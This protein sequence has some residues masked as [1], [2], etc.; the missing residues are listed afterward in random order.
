MWLRHRNQA[1]KRGSFVCLG[2]K[3]KEATLKAGYWCILTR[4]KRGSWCLNSSK[5]QVILI[6]LM[7]VPIYQ[8][9]HTISQAL[10]SGLCKMISFDHYGNLVNGSNNLTV[11]NFRLL[12]CKI[13][14]IMMNSITKLPS[15]VRDRF[16]NPGASDAWEQMCQGLD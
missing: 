12:I 3:Y 16:L 9:S 8:M 5:N 2:K 11:L 6:I 10:R 15:S 14:I 13:K 4:L 1:E 7:V